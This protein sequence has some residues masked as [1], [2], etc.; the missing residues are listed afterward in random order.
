VNDVSAKIVP[1]P[2]RP[3]P[4][5]YLTVAELS[6]VLGMSTRWLAY[7]IQEGLPSYRYGR[8]RRFRLSEVEPWLEKRYGNES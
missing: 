3:L 2:Q 7:R 4:E 6:E 1:F 5:R 8:A